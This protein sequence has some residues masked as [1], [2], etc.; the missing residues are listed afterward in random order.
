MDA[1]VI[2]RR[3]DVVIWETF[4]FL[5]MDPLSIWN[6]QESVHIIPHKWFMYIENSAWT[7]KL[8]KWQ[9]RWFVYFSVA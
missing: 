6:G 8:K 9:R 7:A 5:A 4:S 1:N 2:F 3:V